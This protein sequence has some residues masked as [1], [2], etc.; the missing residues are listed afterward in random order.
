VLTVN[1]LGQ[2][3]TMTD[4]NGTVHSYKYD[5]VG[6]QTADAITTLGS[7]VNGTVRRLNTA[8]DT[9]GNPDKVLLNHDYKNRQAQGRKNKKRIA[10]RAATV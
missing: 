10:R 9:Q 8:Y 4:R 3:L 2:A 6:R 1:A 7:G 5:V